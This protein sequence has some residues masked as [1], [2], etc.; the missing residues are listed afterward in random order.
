M[1]LEVAALNSLPTV[2][3]QINEDKSTIELKKFRPGN[4]VEH[5]VMVGQNCFVFTYEL[6]DNC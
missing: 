4:S 3:V 1:A 6:F 5:R 2:E